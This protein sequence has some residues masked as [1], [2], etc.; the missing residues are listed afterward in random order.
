MET[1]VVVV[2]LACA[3]FG[4]V[5]LLALFNHHWSQQAMEQDVKQGFV[6]VNGGQGYPDY[7]PGSMGQ[8]PGDSMRSLAASLPQRGSGPG[9][10]PFGPGGPLPPGSG[11]T[12]P[13]DTTPHGSLGSLPSANTIRQKKTCC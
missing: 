13:F 7:M 9:V 3:A 4:L 6:A 2:L 12:S 1:V 10:A 11:R 5:G 8:L